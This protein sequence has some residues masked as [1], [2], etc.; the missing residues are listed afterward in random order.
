MFKNCNGFTLAETVS[1]LIIWIMIATFLLPNFLFIV[2]ERKNLQL[3]QS[4]RYTLTNELEKRRAGEMQFDIE[5]YSSGMQ[6]VE[7]T[8]EGNKAVC[9]IYDDYRNVSRERCAIYYED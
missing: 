2:L 7:R 4:I 8:V 5:N 3:E 9:I 1:S 6:I